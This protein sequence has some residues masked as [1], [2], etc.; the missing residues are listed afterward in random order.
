[1]SGSN[2]TIKLWDAQTSS[3]LRTLEGHTNSRIISGSDNN[4]IKLWDAQTSLELRTLEGH[5]SIR[6]ISA[7]GNNTI[8][9]WDVQTGSELQTLEG[10]TNISVAFSPDGQRIV[11]G[12]NNNTIKLWDA[13]TG[14]ELRTLEGHSSSTSNV[15]SGKTQMKYK[16]GSQ[17]SV[18]NSW[19][20]LRGE[21]LLWLSPELRGP[22]C[23]DIRN[24]TLVLGY[25][26]GH[27][28]I[29]RFC[30]PSN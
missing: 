17:I 29:I 1:M 6:I 3:E 26:D 11:S 2:N 27:V 28:L 14:S 9:L 30:A 7:S 12:S 19:V 25:P 22:V 8:K 15:S 16:Q 5:S 23:Y 13:Q 20:C 21:R 18:E 24:Y 10:Y 4:T